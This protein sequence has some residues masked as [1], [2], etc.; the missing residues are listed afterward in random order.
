MD[1][2]CLIYSSNVSVLK[3]RQTRRLLIA[4]QL[5]SSWHIASDVELHCSVCVGMKKW[6]WRTNPSDNA[7]TWTVWTWSA[8]HSKAAFL[9]NDRSHFFSHVGLH[10][11]LPLEI[12]G[13][14][15]ICN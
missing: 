10:S 15:K 13:D 2:Q 11:A 1:S 14:V 7:D 4:Y 9:F 12:A 3:C 5:L 6:R 8:V